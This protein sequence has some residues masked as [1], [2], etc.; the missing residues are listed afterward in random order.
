MF[1]VSFGFLS[2]FCYN[3]YVIY[4][5]EYSDIFMQNKDVSNVVKFSKTAFPQKFEDVESDSNRVIILKKQNKSIFINVRLV[6]FIN[7]CDEVCD[8]VV[9][10]EIISEIIRKNNDLDHKKRQ[11]H[12]DSA[13]NC[14]DCHFGYVIPPFQNAFC[15]SLKAFKKEYDFNELDQ[16]TTK[17]V[18]NVMLVKN[19]MSGAMVTDF[20]RTE[21]GYKNFAIL[22]DIDEM[23][24]Q[25]L[26][27]FSDNVAKNKLKLYMKVG[28]TLDELGTLDKTY[29]KPL[30]HILED[31]GFLDRTCPVLIGGNCLEKDDFRFL[32][33]HEISNF[34]ICPSEDGKVGRRMTNVLQLKNLDFVVGLGSGYSYSVD[35][36]AYMR[37]ILLT[38]RSIFED[39]NCLTEK[40]VLLMA[41]SGTS[42]CENPIDIFEFTKLREGQKANFVVINNAFEEDEPLQKDLMKELVW[43]KSKHDV[44]LV[45]MCGEIWQNRNFCGLLNCTY[46]DLIKRLSKKVKEIKK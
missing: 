7:C 8:I 40:D 9:E 43:N 13:G 4:L 11:K 24:D 44:E 14:F 29:K 25:E 38:M 45:V 5:W 28:Q 15:D 6:D 16:E 33:E 31:F 41:F 34:V 39:E 36:F 19:L 1:A 26:N 10:N 21:N 17:L 20:S 23:S 18:Q 12:C 35:M 3:V 2:V 22:N 46:D 37:Q 30:T 32:K 27:D 42:F